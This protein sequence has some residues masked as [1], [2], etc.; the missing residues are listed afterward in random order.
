MRPSTMPESKGSTT[1][2]LLISLAINLRF[3]SLFH[4]NRSR[5]QT[6]GAGEIF[7]GFLGEGVAKMQAN[8]ADRDFLAPTRPNLL[9]LPIAPRTF[10]LC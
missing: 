9:R 6:E 10:K 2:C 1:L 4:H 3:L 7:A 8:P 5:G